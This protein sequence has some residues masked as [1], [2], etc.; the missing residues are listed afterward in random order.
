MVKKFIGSVIPFMFFHLIC[1]G[2]LLI[3]LTTSGYL[4]LIRQEGNKKILLLPLLLV[5]V[6]L[7]FL[8]WYWGRCC[9]KKGHKSLGDYIFMITLYIAFSSIFGIAFMI[10]VFIPWWIPN[11]TG[12][13]L[14]P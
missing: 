12:G 4:L 3:F 11:Y 2:A 14:L 10:Y 13:S 9:E 5:G 6:V 1:C 8:H 7:F